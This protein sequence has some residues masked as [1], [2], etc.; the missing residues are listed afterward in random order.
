MFVTH[1]QGEAALVADRI[2]IMMDARLVQL[3]S[4]RGVLDAPATAEVQRF[5]GR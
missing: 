4:V 3:G 1:D 2:G 5:L